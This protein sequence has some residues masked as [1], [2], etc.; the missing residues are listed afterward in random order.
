MNRKTTG[1]H[2]AILS[3]MV[4]GIGVAVYFLYRDVATSSDVEEQAVEYEMNYSAAGTASEAEVTVTESV[5]ESKP[6]QKIAAEKASVTAEVKVPRGPFA[7]K[8]C[9]T[10]R[11]N[12][13]SQNADHSLVLKD[14]G[15]SLWIASFSA[16]LCGRVGELDYYANGKIQFA[17]CAGSRLYVIDRLGRFVKSFP[18]ELDRPVLLGPDVYDFNGHQV[19]NIMVLHDDNTVQMYNMKA[20]KPSSWKG[21]K[22]KDTI[23]DLPDLINVGGKSFW[24]LPT[25]AEKLIF[26]FYGGK[27]VN[28]GCV[29]A[30]DSPVKVLNA[31]SV[32]VETADGRR[33]TVKIR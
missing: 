10:G 13:L 21:M 32:Q 8:N 29:I 12:Q 5:P 22:A 26:P 30:K 3:V 25:A 18:K 1:I 6:V 7:I 17:F 15:K 11:M 19:Y 2:L 31:S 24:I 9:K 23:I 20:Q 27:P 28:T 4:L 33:V 14:G 16:P